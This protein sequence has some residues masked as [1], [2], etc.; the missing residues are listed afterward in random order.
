MSLLTRIA[1]V[2]LALL[3]CL[4]VASHTVFYGG[5][6]KGADQRHSENFAAG[7]L[8]EGWIKPMPGADVGSGTINGM[9]AVGEGVIVVGDFR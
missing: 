9:A 3:C 5:D 1:L 4:S 6:F 2:L 7:S 8:E